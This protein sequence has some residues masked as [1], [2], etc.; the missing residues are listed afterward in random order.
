[1][2][3]TALVLGVIGI[4]MSGVVIFAIYYGPIR[5]LKAE[6]RLDAELKERN[7]KLSIKKAEDQARILSV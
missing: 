2:D 1:M 6:R 7:R 4:F 3:R 5:A